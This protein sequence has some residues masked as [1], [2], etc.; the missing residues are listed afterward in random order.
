VYHDIPI[1]STC[2]ICEPGIDTGDILIR[3]RFKG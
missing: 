2:H 1:G 3:Q